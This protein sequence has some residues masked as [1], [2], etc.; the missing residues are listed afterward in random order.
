[1]NFKHFKYI[2]NQ[3]INHLASA[4]KVKH[5]SGIIDNSKA[6]TNLFQ[7]DLQPEICH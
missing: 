2:S 4:A 7:I 5:M 1:M 3:I 6:F